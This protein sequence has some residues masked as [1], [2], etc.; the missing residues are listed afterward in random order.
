METLG[1]VWR[2]T[3]DIVEVD[4]DKLL[5]EETGNANFFENPRRLSLDH[6]D[7]KEYKEH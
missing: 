7:L 5:L 2:L 6:L 1:D 3:C 4:V